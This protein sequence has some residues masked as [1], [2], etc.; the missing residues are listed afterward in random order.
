[1]KKFTEEQTKAAWG[2]AI[3]YSAYISAT[4]S[5]FDNKDFS[6][7]KLI[8]VFAWADTLIADQELTGVALATDVAEMKDYVRWQLAALRNR[9]AA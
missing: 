2:L 8:E 1:M 4:R 9:Q 6:E 5:M 3:S 7:K